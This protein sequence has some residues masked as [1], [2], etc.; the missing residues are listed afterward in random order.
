MAFTTAVGSV[1]DLQKVG[2]GELYTTSPYSVEGASTFED[3]LKIGRFA[4]MASGSLDNLDGS[5][6]PVIAGV[7]L[8]PISNTY[9]DSAVIDTDIHNLAEFCRKGMVLVAAKAGETPTWGD[10][11]FASNAGDSNDG[12]ATV[13][14]TDVATGARY[15]ETVDT[16]LWRVELDRVEDVTNLIADMGA[17]VTYENLNANSDIG[18]SAGQLIDGD[19]YVA[20]LATKTAIADL[21]STAN[22]KGASLVG[23]EDAGTFTASA[24]VEAALAEMLPAVDKLAVIAD[25][26]DAGAIPV[27]RSGVCA[28][29]TAAAAETRTLAV[30]ASVGI[31][32]SIICDT[33][34]VGDAVIT[35]ASAI[36]QTGNNTI[37]LGA[38]ADMIELKSMTVG[39]S[40]VWR[41]VAND[42]AALTTV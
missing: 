39:G 4:K 19:T 1:T 30:P 10:P 35:V 17:I 36:N 41:V 16:N 22:A 37:T 7:V 11:I 40:I 6:S 32:L 33:Y 26:G 27:L 38:A 8:R 3:Q 34:A 29:T 14:N 5:A 31:T 12:L 2:A 25:P 21:A 13:T 42:G 15:L 23:I 28:I 18:I 9:E 24:T 20:G